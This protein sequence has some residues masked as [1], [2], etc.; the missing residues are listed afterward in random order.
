VDINKKRRKVPVD[1][2][3]DPLEE[4]ESGHL[5]IIERPWR[6]PAEKMKNQRWFSIG[7]WDFD[8]EIGALH[9]QGN[10][11]WY[12][13]K[14]SEKNPLVFSSKEMNGNTIVIYINKDRRGGTLVIWCYDKTIDCLAEAEKVACH[15]CGILS[16]E[17]DMKLDWGFL[18]LLC[19]SCFIQ[20]NGIEG[21]NRIW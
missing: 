9:T 20:E 8:S 12:G 11:C 10:S 18:K 7:E 5:N 14:Q 6:I 17:K 2:S 1:Y 16:R 13:F 4:D 3:I 19:R 15:K 21:W